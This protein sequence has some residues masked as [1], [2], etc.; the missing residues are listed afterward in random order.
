VLQHQSIE[1]G[2]YAAAK[3]L[4]ASS[5]RNQVGVGIPAL[6]VDKRAGMTHVAAASQHL[7]HSFWHI[8]AIFG[9]RHPELCVVGEAFAIPSHCLK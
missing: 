4:A 6:R 8:A 7:W 5:E 2:G 3:V 9:L 1:Y